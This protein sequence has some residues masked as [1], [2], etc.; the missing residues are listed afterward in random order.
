M[1]SKAGYILPVKIG[2]FGLCQSLH[3]QNEELVTSTLASRVG[4]EDYMA[5]EVFTN[6]YFFQ[7]HWVAS[8][9]KLFN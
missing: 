1:F 4:T 5:P 6:D 2:D 9:G 8:F 3:S 7:C